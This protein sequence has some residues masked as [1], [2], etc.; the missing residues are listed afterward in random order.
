MLVFNE[1]PSFLYLPLQG[2]L[3]GV[4]ISDLKL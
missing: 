3:Q 2:G 1:L 4:K